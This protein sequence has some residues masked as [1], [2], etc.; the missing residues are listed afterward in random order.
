MITLMHIDHIL[1][2]INAHTITSSEVK[3]TPKGHTSQS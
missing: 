2:E 1:N 3:E